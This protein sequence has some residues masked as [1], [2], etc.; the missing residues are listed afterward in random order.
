MATI[1][2]QRYL[3]GLL[4]CRSIFMWQKAA[5]PRWYSK[6]RL[7]SYMTGVLAA[8]PRKWDIFQFL[9]WNTGS[10]DND[11]FVTAN[12]RNVSPLRAKVPIFDCQW[13]IR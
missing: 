13:A 1:H 4:M 5:Q 6:P 10:G 11:Y 12:I 7:T 9:I 3:Y 2:G 8:K